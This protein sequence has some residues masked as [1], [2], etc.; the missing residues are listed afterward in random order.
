[1]IGQL[2]LPEWAGLAATAAGAAL[3]YTL[4]GFGFAVLSTPGFLL[5]VDPSQAVQLVIIISTALSI[6]TLPRL[7]RAIAPG[8][9]LRLTLG[10]LAGLPLGLIALRHADPV[11]VRR[12][13]GITILAFTVV[14]GWVRLRGPRRQM[15][16]LGLKPSRDLAVGTISGAATALV[17]MA[18]PPVL[19]YLLFAG[20]PPPTVRA[21]LLSFFG[22][23]YA[24][25]LLSHA[26]AL[27][28][29]AGTW[30][31]A[32]ILIPF[33]ALGAIAGRPL[34]DRLGVQAFAVL[35]I[36]LLATA[37]LY[38]LAAS[39]GPATRQ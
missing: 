38:T 35:A 31:G 21:T 33:A 12:L 13:I 28:I 36:M 22:I 3:L 11:V 26:I 20:A 25:A 23:V 32:G 37:G 14:L 24:A 15:A 5:L 29:S 39:A 8:L 18:G 17:G 2:S 19:I 10:S 30:L 1:V 4:T 27:G 6:T 9:L 34:G 7:W 16:V